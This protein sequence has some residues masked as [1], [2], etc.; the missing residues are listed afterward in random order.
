[1]TAT[2]Q[3]RAMLDERG[4]EWK[5]AD[6]Y[7]GLTDR[8]TTSNGYWFHEFGDKLT[9]AL[10]HPTAGHRRHTGARGVPSVACTTIRRRCHVVQQLRR[11]H[12]R[13]CVG[14]LLPA[15]WRTSREAG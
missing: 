12:G 9:V 5:A 14:K 3:L 7:E 1:M 6:G 2:E 13:L 15:L 11:G 8:D 10:P 4:V